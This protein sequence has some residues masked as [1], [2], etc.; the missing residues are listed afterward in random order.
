MKS[1]K[2]LFKLSRSQWI[3]VAVLASSLGLAVAV[4]IPN[5]FTAGT[6]ISAA[7]MNANF[8]AMGTAVTAAETT[9]A[10]AQGQISTLQTALSNSSLSAASNA[11]G[12]TALTTTPVELLGIDFT[13]PANGF[14]MAQAHTVVVI[15]HTNTIAENVFVK[16]STAVETGSVTLGWTQVIVPAALP[17]VAGFR[18]P[19][20]VSSRFSCTGGVAARYRLNASLPNGAGT[21]DARFHV[22]VLHY[23][24]S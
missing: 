4:T 11:S 10:T 24:P 8:A 3:G 13:C 20:S 14:V 23:S 18:I 2:K 22:L 16:V 1:G 6:A 17:T 15:D 21:A 7:Q 9:L 19:T 12:I 5:T